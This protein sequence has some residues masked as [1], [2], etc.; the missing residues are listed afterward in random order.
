MLCPSVVAVRQAAG[1]PV[2]MA[3]AYDQ[4]S[5]DASLPCGYPLR[6][7]RQGNSTKVG[8]AAT[9]LVVAANRNVLE[10][11]IHNGTRLKDLPQVRVR[12]VARDLVKLVLVAR[13]V[14]KRDVVL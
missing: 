8:V 9:V 2:T 13:L 4:Q 5:E 6:Q 10:V 7:L 3:Q 11:V 12:E 14:V 1:I